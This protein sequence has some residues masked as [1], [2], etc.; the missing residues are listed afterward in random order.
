MNFTLCGMTIN[1]SGK[2]KVQTLFSFGPI[3]SGSE[4]LAQK[5]GFSSGELENWN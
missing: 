3:H 1:V 4:M 2:P 5:F